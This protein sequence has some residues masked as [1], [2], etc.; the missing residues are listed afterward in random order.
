MTWTGKDVGLHDVAFEL[1]KRHEIVYWC[2]ISLDTEVDS[3]QFPRTVFHDFFDALAGKPATGVDI[4]NFQ[5]PGEDLIKEF[6]ETELT[7]LTMMNKKYQKVLLEERK[8]LYYRLLGYW[9]GVLLALKPDAIIYDFTPHSVYDFVVYDIAKKMGIKTIIFQPVLLSNTLQIVMN[10]YKKGS[11]GLIDQMKRNA[12]CQFSISDIS[13]DIR[14]HYQKNSGM[15]GDVPPL[16]VQQIFTRYSGVRL[17]FVKLRSLWTSLTVHKDLSVLVTVLMY[18]PRRF[19]NNLKKEY[20]RVQ[21][22][23]DFGKKFV[24]VALQYQPEAQACPQA[25][26]F[27]DQLLLIEILS[28]ALPDGWL[29]YVKEHPVLWLL[30]GLKFYDFRFRGY[31]ETIAKIKNVKLIPVDTDSF[32]LIRHSQAVA[33]GAGSVG[34]EAILRSKPVLVFGY[35][36]YQQC[37]GAFKI[38]DSDTCKEALSRIENGF[39]VSQQ[40]VINFL[41]CLSKVCTET[42]FEAYAKGI[43]K[44]GRE[45]NIRNLVQAIE[46]ELQGAEL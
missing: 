4:S 28:S 15:N 19:K 38:A 29:V 2:G 46:T 5:P 33:T 22:K 11:A 17:F 45:Q 20:H 26:V 31:Y 14:A 6:Q 30:H 16:Y 27:A 7:V 3:T 24:Y 12:H 13:P 40:R 1:Q 9:Y 42:Y 8:H 36:W 25:G 44:I 37:E 41:A 21:S 39:K 18:L 10:D 34:W 23:V 43:S 32:Q 35:P